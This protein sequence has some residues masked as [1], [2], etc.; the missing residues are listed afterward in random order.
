MRRFLSIGIIGIFALLAIAA[1]ALPASAD[2]SA[3]A[4]AAAAFAYLQ[5]NGDA[6]WAQVLVILAALCAITGAASW[7]VAFLT[8]LVRWT[9][10]KTD[11]TVLAFVG[12]A[13]DVL[14]AVL[15]RV[16][17]NP[18][19]INARG[20]F[21]TTVGEVMEALIKKVEPRATTSEVKDAV[22][23]FLKGASVLLLAA[24]LAATG[25]AGVQQQQPQEQRAG[26]KY[27][28]QQPSITYNNTIYA[29]DSATV[30]NTLGQSAQDASQQGSAEQGQAATT[31]S[32]DNKPNVSPT[33]SP[34]VSVTP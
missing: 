1:A 8:P 15:S 9:K 25:C 19:K 23:K 12:R 27:G 4:T 32:V 30:I 24:A 10:N 31:G 29:S 20:M 21:T 34:T 2:T 14:H 7:L 13:L 22:G 33:I 17:A 26:D 11:N 16:A 6:A 28:K 18:N 3:T 5:Q